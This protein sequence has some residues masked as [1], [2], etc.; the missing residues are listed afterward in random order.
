MT[1]DEEKVN[2]IL[3]TIRDS[4]NSQ[5]EMRGPMNMILHRRTWKMS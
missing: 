5:V 4:R 2:N 3:S 1:D